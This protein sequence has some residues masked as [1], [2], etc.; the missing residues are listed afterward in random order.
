[1][2]KRNKI[3]IHILFWFYILNQSLFPLYINKMHE[4]YYNDLFISMLL[5]V[6]C[7]YAFYISLT[8]LLR[9]SK[10]VSIFLI[11][12][13]I[14]VLLVPLRVGLDYLYWKYIALLPKKELVITSLWVGNELRMVIICIIYATLIRFTIDWF[15]SQKIKTELINR[16]Q[17]SELALLRSQVNPHFLFNTLNNI[18]ALVY[19]KS[20]EAPAAVM[21]LSSLMRYMLYDSSIDKVLLEKEI[22]YIKSFI[23]LQELRLKSLNFVEFKVIGNIEG[24]KIA[25]MLLIPYVENAFKHCS[26]SESPGIFISIETDSY[27]L[28]LKI[29]NYVKEE[30]NQC[31]QPSGI[32]L[33]N[34][35][36]RLELLYPDQHE[37]LIRKIDNLYQ[38]DLRINITTVTRN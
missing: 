5:N 3:L 7:F 19:N 29:K 16:Q 34:T 4:H 13:V 10:M 30:N 14:V 17:S 23:E 6:I 26:K 32:G 12:A 25:P 28:V 24:I 31:E 8:F 21:K 2:L 15:D 33:I 18:Y 36:R 38:V 20:D 22:D 11:S 35:K 9:K 27:E 37:L 1:M